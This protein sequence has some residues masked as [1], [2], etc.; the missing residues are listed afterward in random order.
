M[1]PGVTALTEQHG[2]KNP[3]GTAINYHRAQP[4]NNHTSNYNMSSE[5]AAGAKISPTISWLKQGI[6]LHLTEHSTLMQGL[7]A[8]LPEAVLQPAVLL[9]D[10]FPW[11]FE[12][13]VVLCLP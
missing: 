6:S 1:L 4:G 12:T 7:Q 2:C 5:V 11:H 13:I 10:S 9:K 8:G 3:R